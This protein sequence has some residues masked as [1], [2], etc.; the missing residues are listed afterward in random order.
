MKPGDARLPRHVAIIMDGNG[1]WAKQRGL[2]RVAG[3]HEGVHSVREIVEVA[4]EFGL[5][6]LTLYTFSSENWRR[7]A[8][9]VNALMQLLLTTVGREVSRLD[10]NQVRLDLIGDLDAIPAAPRKALI[11]AMEQTADNT[12]LR[13][14]LALSYGGRQEILQAVN[15]LLRE[16]VTEV[17]EE[18]F[19]QRLYTAGRPDPDLLIRTGGEMRISNFLL[20]QIAYT[21]FY[22]SE[23]LW[24]DFR[25]EQFL[26]ALEA[27]A[28]RERRFGQTSE[29]V[30]Q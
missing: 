14:T 3:H 29:Q 25:R 7:P 1:R 11:K 9:E 16:G 30:S 28:N 22:L 5:S 6:E 26:S 10:R 18:G 23:A 21:E 8:L 19:S 4:G 27:Y 2:P 17:D 20:W 12:G 13:L 15:G 24:P